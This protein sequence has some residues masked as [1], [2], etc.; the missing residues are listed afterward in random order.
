MPGKNSRVLA[1]KPCIQWTI[2]AARAARRAHS[3]RPLHRRPPASTI[4]KAA[5]VNVIQPPDALASD[6]TTINRRP[7]R[8]DDP[9]PRRVHAGGRPHRP[10]MLDPVVILYANVPIRPAGLIDRAIELCG[11]RLRQRAELCPVGK[12][13][14]HKRS[15]LTP[16]ARSARGKV[17]CSTTASSAAVSTRVYPR[18]AVIVVPTA[19][20]LKLQ[21]FPRAARLL[22][23]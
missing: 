9:R 19:L 4:G 8:G 14:P 16:A 20:L 10:T 7:P 18:R 11:P 5:G 22:R 6:T 23:R 1:G 13:H 17:T 15:G 21:E 12:Y 2:D 3:R